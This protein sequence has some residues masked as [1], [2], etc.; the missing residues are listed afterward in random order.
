MRGP[1]IQVLSTALVN[2]IAAGEVIERPASVVKELVENALDAGAAAVVVEIE[3]GGRE[4]IRVIDD[5]QGIPP[6]QLTLAFAEHATSKLATDD[7][8]FR[9]TTMGF[10]GEAL[11]SIGSVSHARILSRT[12]ESPAAYEIFDRGGEISQPQAAAGNRG[13]TLEVRNLF[14]NTPARRKF[15]RGAATEF[16]HIRE[17]VLRLALPHPDVAFTL[18]HNGRVALELGPTTAKERLLAAWP[19]DFARQHLAV[20]QADAEM[21]VHGLAGLPEL[22][23]ATAKHQFFYLNGRHIRDRF[24]QHAVKEAYRGL[25]EPGRQPAVI[26][27]LHLPPEDVDVNVHPTKI[28]SAAS[29]TAAGFMA[30]FW[31]PCVSV[32]SAPIWRP[33]RR[34]CRRRNRP[35]AW[36]CGRSSPLFF[37]NFLPPSRHRSRCL[38]C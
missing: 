10:R 2:R 30:W 17:M 13:T 23:H 29:G 9:I 36:R 20:E 37:S 14:F 5:G 31:R 38:I 35:I 15:M 16:G 22:A 7:D 1:P 3:D 6:D 28:E 4:L 32:Y 25:M 24:I 33:T 21:R 34:S 18:S 27:M 11:A 8:L 26:M 19:A 12:E